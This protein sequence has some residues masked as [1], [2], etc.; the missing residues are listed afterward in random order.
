M[1]RNK[2]LMVLE[3][4]YRARPTRK[5]NAGERALVDEAQMYLDALPP[6]LQA[7]VRS[8]G[9]RGVAQLVERIWELAHSHH[10]RLEDRV[11]AAY[12]LAFVV[13]ELP[14]PM[15]EEELSAHIAGILEELDA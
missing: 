9:A 8:R 6:E 4:A 12:V 14:Q 10:D 13:P 3:A 1:T 15:K 5:E 2:R 11:L 7:R